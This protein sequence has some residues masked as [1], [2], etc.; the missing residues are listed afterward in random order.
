MTEHNKRSLEPLWLS[1]S[2]RQL[3]ANAYG[4]SVVI[5]RRKSSVR[6]I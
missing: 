3:P 5:R 1:V 4:E 6:R 2:Q